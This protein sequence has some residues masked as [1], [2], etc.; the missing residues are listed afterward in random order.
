[1]TSSPILLLLLA[2]T[3][4]CSATG[5][6]SFS[7]TTL[8]D[9]VP[10]RYLKGKSGEVTLKALLFKDPNGHGFVLKKGLMDTAAVARGEHRDA[11]QTIGF[12]VMSIRSN[13][14]FDADTQMFAAGYLE[15]YLTNDRIRQMFKNAKAL[16]NAQLLDKVYGYIE[17]QDGYLR[18]KAKELGGA[19]KY[20]AHVGH[21]VKQLDGLVQGY[22]DHCAKGQQ[23]STG[24]LWLLNM[25]GD[26]L[27]VERAYEGGHAAAPNVMTG[28]LPKLAQQL[29]FKEQG[30]FLTSSSNELV[31]AGAHQKAKVALD[32]TE[33]NRLMRR[34]MGMRFSEKRGGASLRAATRKERVERDGGAVVRRD[35]E[36]AK[37]RFSEALWNKQ[38]QKTRCSAVVTL[39]ED[40]SNFFVGHST[41][42]DYSELLRMYVCVRVCTCVYGWVCTRVVIRGKDGGASC[43]AEHSTKCEIH[44]AGG[45]ILLLGLSS[46]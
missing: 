3:S 32:E 41:W 28:N 36:A 12:G 17:A 39:A 6:P 21:V 15:G 22:N 24:D 43:K 2:A 25:D 11:V 37:D 14:D 33:W 19:D 40:N 29:R 27:D 45:A 4:A 46:Q 1:M 5:A 8:R 20:W 38:V 35:S 44:G 13:P 26:V 10:V 31:E 18:A 7:I 30:M 23:L 16:R 9:V 34:S 42:S